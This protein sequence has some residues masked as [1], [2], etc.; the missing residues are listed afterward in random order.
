[1]GRFAAKKAALVAA[2][3]IMVAWAILVAHANTSVILSAA[4]HKSPLEWID[5]GEATWYEHQDPSQGYRLRV[6]SMEI[7][8]VGDYLDENG[9]SRQAAEQAGIS[10]VDAG[11]V[12]AVC[13]E[14]ENV[15]DEAGNG[16]SPIEIK[17]TG[18]SPSKVLSFD[19]A[20]FALTYP[21]LGDGRGF[22]VKPHTSAEVTIPLSADKNTGYF[23]SYE[24]SY[25]Q[26]IE[27]GSFG[28]RVA[29]HPVRIIVDI[30]PA[31]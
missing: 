17:A 25:R 15:S 1:M 8:S 3:V 29:E 28:V 31:A 30:S 16:F 14:V 10:L 19:S 13:L 27:G 12:A 23:E 20:L 4:E 11:D 2:G 6:K 22:T 24:K 5:L 7:V 21:Q 9:I 26:R 18:A